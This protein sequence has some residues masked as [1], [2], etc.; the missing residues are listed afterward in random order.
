M[1][2][3]AWTIIAFCAGLLVGMFLVALME[4]AKDDEKPKRW[5]EDDG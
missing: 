3:W 5:W 2:H 4:T 1:I